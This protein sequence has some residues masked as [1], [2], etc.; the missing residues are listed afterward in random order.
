MANIE[1]L[2]AKK[3][4]KAILKKGFPVETKVVAID[5]AK[6]FILLPRVDSILT[7]DLCYVKMLHLGKNIYEVELFESYKKQHFAWH[8]VKRIGLTNSEIDTFLNILEGDGSPFELEA[9]D[10]LI[11]KYSD[12]DHQQDQAEA[13]AE[14]LESCDWVLEKLNS[15]A[16]EISE[17]INK[18]LRK[19]HKDNLEFSEE[20]RPDADILERFLFVNSKNPYFYGTINEF[21]KRPDYVTILKNSGA[22]DSFVE[23][24]CMRND[25]S[26]DDEEWTGEKEYLN[27]VLESELHTRNKK[28]T[29]YNDLWCV[30]GSKT[31]WRGSGFKGLMFRSTPIKLIMKA[32]GDREVDFSITIPPEQ[33]RFVMTHHHHDATSYYTFMPVHK[34]YKK[35]SDLDECFENAE[36]LN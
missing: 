33:D 28:Y 17:N 22:W 18:V 6:K 21:V 11:F 14:D 24:I 27:E 34:M 15:N 29:C 7:R 36:V 20:Y 32:I 25:F 5:K 8:S 12:G 9:A 2:A 31:N 1:T 26:M 30:D 4:W 35:Y 10:K 13:H 3:S 16:D 23:D 19:A